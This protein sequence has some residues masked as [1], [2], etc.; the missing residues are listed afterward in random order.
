MTKQDYVIIASV[1]RHANLSVSQRA[2]LTLDMEEALRPTNENWNSRLWH[3]ACR[4]APAERVTKPVKTRV[5]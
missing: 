4:Q 2:A 1:I 5:N 3:E